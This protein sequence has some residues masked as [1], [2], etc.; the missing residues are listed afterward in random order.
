MTQW[1]TPET[2]TYVGAFGGAG[3]GLLGAIVGPLCG[4]LV[5]RNRGRG[6]VLGML[7][8]L[9]LIGAALLVTGVVALVESQPY[10]VW[11][12]LTLMGFVGTA[13]GTPLFFA[14]RMRYRAMEQRKMDAELMRK[15]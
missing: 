7:G 6:V 11:F 5:P 8:A 12:P 3:L 13:V 1:W 2:G 9:T 4:Y 15:G 14:T 10:H